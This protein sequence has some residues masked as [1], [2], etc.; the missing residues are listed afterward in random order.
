VTLLRHNVKPDVF[1]IVA[2]NM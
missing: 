1:M 2:I